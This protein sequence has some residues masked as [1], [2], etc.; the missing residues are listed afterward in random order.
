MKKNIL[1]PRVAE[2][3]WKHTEDDENNTHAMRKK[4]DPKYKDFSVS[5]TFPEV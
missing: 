1:Y 3:V 4:T 2:I 5:K